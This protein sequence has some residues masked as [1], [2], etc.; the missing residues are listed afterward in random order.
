MPV[1]EVALYCLAD[2]STSME[3][4]ASDKTEENAL[5]EQLFRS[6]VFSSLSSEAIPLRLKK[7]AIRIIGDQEAYF[8][9][10]PQQLLNTLDLLF[11]TLSHPLLM[12]SSASAI[13]NLVE[14][15]RSHLSQ[16]RLLSPHQRPEAGWLATPPH[17]AARLS[18]KNFLLTL[19]TGCNA[20]AVG[21][22]SRA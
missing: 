18:S 6:V 11:G 22:R 20:T 19:C 12:E 13:R 10:Q 2:I 14:S 8:E 3:Y 15:G 21:G 16:V 9:S 5:L 17:A 1:A 7:R 4:S